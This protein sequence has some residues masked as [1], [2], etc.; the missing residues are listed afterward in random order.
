M[1]HNKPNFKNGKICIP[2]DLIFFFGAKAKKFFIK[3]NQL[4]FVE[5]KNS[6]EKD[7]FLF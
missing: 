1:N 2:F 6:T 7:L 5:L 4:K 3:Q